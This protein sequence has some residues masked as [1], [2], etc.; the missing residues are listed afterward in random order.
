MIIKTAVEPQF[1]QVFPTYKIAG[2][3]DAHNLLSHTSS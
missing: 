1:V 2:R 3:G